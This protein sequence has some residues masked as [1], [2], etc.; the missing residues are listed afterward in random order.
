MTTTE[1]EQMLI[2]AA[3]K[4]MG[5]RPYCDYL[6]HK[7]RSDK[8]LREEYI[9]IHAVVRYQRYAGGEEIELGDEK[10]GWD[11]WIA[12]REIFEVAQA[13]PEGEYE[14]R[15][16][17]AS[18]SASLMLPVHSPNPDE[19][20]ELPLTGPL[21]VSLL[22]AQHARDHHQFPTAIITAIEKK[23]RKKYA[24][25]RTLIVVFDGDYSF[26][27]DQTIAKWIE[28]IHRQTT[29]GTFKAIYLVE[30]DRAKVFPVFE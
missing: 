8:Y 10:Q 21:A 23:H 28:E 19:P 4:R 1:F 9:A 12:G 15:R 18:G 26:E 7:D 5:I 6:Q 22:Q 25:T 3:Q 27:D 16:A 24:D 14:I 2:D 20:V 13:L 29:R 30:R 11:A 17:I